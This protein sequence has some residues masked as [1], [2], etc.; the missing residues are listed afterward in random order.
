MDANVD[1]A[2]RLIAAI[3]AGDPDAVRALYADDFVIWHN[4]DGQT[5]TKEENLAVL[6]WLIRNVKDRRYENV[7]RSPTPTGFVQQHV[8]RGVWPNGQALELP[9]C[10]IGEV[11]DGLITRLDE[12]LDSAAVPGRA[13]AQG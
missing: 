7:R 12:Y 4:N 11:R 10:L 13:P 9:A 1:I 6:G 8:L 3:E 5:Q 2:A